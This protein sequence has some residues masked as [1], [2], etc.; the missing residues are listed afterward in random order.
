M[1]DLRLA[2]TRTEDANVNA[3][4]AEVVAWRGARAPPRADL[5]LL[6][7]LANAEARGLTTAELQEITGRLVQGVLSS[8]RNLRRQAYI[9]WD[10]ARW[11]IQQA[12]CTALE[13]A[14]GDAAHLEL[15]LRAVPGVRVTE[16]D[17][18]KG[19]HRI[20]LRRCPVPFRYLVFKWIESLYGTPEEPVRSSI[21][22]NAA[23]WVFILLQ[24]YADHHPSDDDL[25]HLNA[26]VVRQWVRAILP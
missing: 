21:V 23:T 5:Q 4:A 20:D 1:E 16:H 24:F 12:G 25:R 13:L 7:H 9:G 19:Y 15:D 2:P 18:G 26:D 10:G 8:L 14:R 17:V 22:K 6:T 3:P 11:S